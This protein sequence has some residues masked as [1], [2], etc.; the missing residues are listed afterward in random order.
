VK[1][2]TRKMNSNAWVA[3]R[4][5]MVFTLNQF[6]PF[7]PHRSGPMAIDVGLSV[8]QRLVLRWCLDLFI[9]RREKLDNLTKMQ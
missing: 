9:L 7:G 5:A 3:M 1:C 4:N 2:Q 6:L 8:K